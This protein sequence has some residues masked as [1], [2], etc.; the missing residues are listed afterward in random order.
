MMTERIK[1][2]IP[3]NEIRNRQDIENTGTYKENLRKQEKTGLKGKC[4]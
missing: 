3:G 1:F 2:K 4:K